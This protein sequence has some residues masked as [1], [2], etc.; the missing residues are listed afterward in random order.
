M[1]PKNRLG[2]DYLALDL[3]RLVITIYL[4]RKAKDCILTIILFICFKK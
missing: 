4:K 3:K 2:G 1:V